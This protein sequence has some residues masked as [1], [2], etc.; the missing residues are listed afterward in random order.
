MSNRVYT[1]TKITEL[2][3]A[4]YFGEIAALPQ[5]VMSLEVASAMAF[6]MRIFRN[7]ILGFSL[8]Q[9]RLFP[10]WNT[11]GQR[12]AC[13]T[14]LNHFLREKIAGAKEKTEREWLLGCKKNLYSAVSNIIRLEEAGA[15]PE[16]IRD[17]DRDMVLFVEMWKCLE[18]IDDSIRNFRN[19]RKE[20]QSPGVFEAE[21]N[22]IFRFHGKKQIVWHGFQFLTPMQQF[23]YD[24]FISAHYDI[25]ALIQDEEQYPYANEIWDYFYTPENGFPEKRDWIRQNNFMSPNVLG[26]I[27]ETGEKVSAQGIKIT[28]YK[29]TIEFVED[30]P[31]IK[32]EGY[33]IYCAD[34]KAAN[35][36][37]K[38]Y[39]PERYEVR[40]LLAYPVGQFVY[41][42]HKMW[43]ENRQCIVLSQNGLRKC[44]ASGW[45]S[46]NGKSSVN[47]TEDMERLLP[48][49]EGCYTV[50]EWSDRLD[51][52]MEAYDNAVSVFE[53][54]SAGEGTDGRKGDIPGNPLRSFGVFSVK[55]DRMAEVTGIIRHLMKLAKTLFGKNEPVSIHEHVSR[56][57]AMLYMQDGMPREL[58]MEEREK[59]KRIFEILES[60]Q[61]RDFR[62]YPGDLA[63]ALLSL[64][65]DKAEE[66]DFGDTGARTL[67]FNLFQVE[68]API[69]AKGKVHVCMADITKLPGAAGK[70]HWPLNKDVL[71][72]IAQ[73]KEGTYIK[74]W[75]ENDQLCA[76]SNRYYIYA[77]LKNQDV[78]ISWI[79]KQGEKL[80]SPSPYITL[81]DKLSDAKVR[82]CDVRK[83]DMQTVWDIMPERRLEK[84]YSIFENQ[85]L[86]SYDSE[87]EYALCP[88]RFVYSRV[89]GNCP[90]YRNEYQQ[91]LA[92]VRLIQSLSK[93]LEGKYNAQQIAEQV[94][95]LFPGIRKAEKR[96]IMDD[97]VK[98]SMPEEDRG[99]TT[100]GEQKYTNYRFNLIFP[101]EESCSEAKK[102]VNRLMSPEGRKG[103]FYDRRGSDGSR[104]CM[105][106][107]HSGYCMEALSSLDYKGEQG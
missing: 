41:T 90:A 6:D 76:L 100:F 46:F 44:F 89:L 87:L 63:A 88:M 14:A 21:V 82:E 78:E 65:G 40:N 42:L 61:I 84:D 81:L 47:Y 23:V 32:K 31:R 34:D 19:R 24:C 64:M 13:M 22:K 99:Y 73:R 103:I 83:M 3:K 85:K 91:N 68:A 66:E 96:Q 75:I 1:Y 29:N 102:L 104:N 9:K 43:D 62:C 17:T 5:I 69:A 95:Q 50:D 25:Y 37:L 86:H 39:F 33:Y 2:K 10:D 57:D 79:E 54:D 4:P 12:F 18:S 97:T 58:Y 38:D 16:D 35:N 8:F 67:V 26:E 106:C 51:C 20:L 53:A 72:H 98:W 28:K 105:F 92:I 7:N 71:Y 36:M 55:K 74:N 48:Y 11:S 70:Y 94:F 27:F 15:T 49:F 101:D 59:V 93:L 80:Y 52:L 56:L 77:A 107:P 60:D 45:L 30:I